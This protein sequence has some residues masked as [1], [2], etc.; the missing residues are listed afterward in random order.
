MTWGQHHD[1]LLASLANRGADSLHG[2]LGGLHF[3]FT[4]GDHVHNV[5]FGGENPDTLGGTDGAEFTWG[6]GGDDRIGGGGMDDVLHGGAVAGQEN[7]KKGDN[8][9]YGGESNKTQ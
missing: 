1:N 5:T 7:K 4:A 8:K 2:A 3:N 6:L 9:V